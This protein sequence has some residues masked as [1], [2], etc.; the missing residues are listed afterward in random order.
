MLS[1][2]AVNAERWA[3]GGERENISTTNRHHP[4]T[5]FWKFR[6]NEIISRETIGDN[7]TCGWREPKEETS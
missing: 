4:F 2:R 6:K 7:L 3:V 5:V 1:R